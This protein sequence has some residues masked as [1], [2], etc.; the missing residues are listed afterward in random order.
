MKPQAPEEVG[1]D[2][3]ILIDVGQG[4]SA[5]GPYAP[6]CGKPAFPKSETAQPT[7]RTSGGTWKTTA[8]LGS[9]L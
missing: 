9:F 1:M 4:P 5:Q 6:C 2:T 8:S 7:G 3:S